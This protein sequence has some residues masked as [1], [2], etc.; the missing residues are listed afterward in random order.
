MF[1]IVQYTMFVSIYFVHF[2]APVSRKNLRGNF[3]DRDEIIYFL[4]INV[5]YFLQLIK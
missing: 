3:K 5:V 1:D 2:I 4:P